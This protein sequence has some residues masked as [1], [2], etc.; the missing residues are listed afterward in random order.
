MQD[1]FYKEFENAEE[2][3]ENVSNEEVVQIVKTENGFGVFIELLNYR[4]YE[5]ALRDE[6]IMLSV[7]M[8]TQKSGNTPYILNLEER[9]S[10]E[11]LRAYRSITESV[12]RNY[13]RTL[14]KLGF[15]Y[16]LEDNQ[17]II[18]EIAED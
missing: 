3:C 12:C 4:E 15:K 5:E 2:V 14:D 10:K 13:F 11:L 9:F 8:R 18:E 7:T 6:L 1:M 17:V 16:K